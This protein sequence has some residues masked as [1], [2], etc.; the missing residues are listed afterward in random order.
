MRND[1]IDRTRSNRE[2]IIPSRIHKIVEP[3]VFVVII[4]VD[5]FFAV[6]PIHEEI[7]GEISI[8]LPESKGKIPTFINACR[9][10]N[11]F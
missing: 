6:L 2:N 10:S 9:E 7:K 8:F 11:W 4:V 1:T 3:I 5:H